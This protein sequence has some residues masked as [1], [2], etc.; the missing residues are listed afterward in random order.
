M[1]QNVI[2]FLLMLICLLAFL[3][4]IYVV[5]SRKL[6]DRVI[7]INLICTIIINAI[8]VLALFHDTAYLLDVCLVF[9]IL[10]FLAVIV[11]CRLLVVRHLE[12]MNDSGEEKKMEGEI[13]ND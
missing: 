4:M 9:A 1:F 10:G 12:Q 7:G 2:L 13:E 8:V 3:A 11:L 5:R 6:E